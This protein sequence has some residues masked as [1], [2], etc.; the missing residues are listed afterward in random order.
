[1][2]PPLP[3]YCIDLPDQFLKL[4]APSMI[5][6][7]SI[8]ELLSLPKVPWHHTSSMNFALPPIFN[9]L[10]G[11][12]PWL[13]EA[14]RRLL[15]GGV[16]LRPGVPGVPGG[17]GGAEVGE[18]GCGR[19]GRA[20]RGGAGHPKA[21]ARQPPAPGQERIRRVKVALDFVEYLY[22]A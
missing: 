16:L 15:S 13:R 5:C 1:M 6:F 11:P 8:L 18:G 21:G 10:A 3:L 9:F 12:G 2:V 14:L 19:G 7:N 22:G 4:R 20:R 17:G